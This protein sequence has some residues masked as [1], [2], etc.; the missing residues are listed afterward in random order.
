MVM[1][2]VCDNCDNWTTITSRLKY[3]LRKYKSA[4]LI[5]IHVQFN[6]LCLVF[7]SKQCFLPNY[8]FTPSQRNYTKCTWLFLVY[9][10]PI[11]KVRYSTIINGIQSAAKVSYD[12]NYFSRGVRNCCV[13]RAKRFWNLFILAHTRIDNHCI[14]PLQCLRYRHLIGL[15]FPFCQSV[16]GRCHTN[17]CRDFT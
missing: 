10:L 1:S 15:R 2:L 12:E 13:N 9:G 7:I 11:D 17:I 4:H 8:A 14:K 6:A 16:T 5:V 3:Q